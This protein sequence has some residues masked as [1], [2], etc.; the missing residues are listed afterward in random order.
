MKVEE[1]AKIGVQGRG[2]TKSKEEEEEED[3]RRS[4]LK[5]KQFHIIRFLLDE[6][7]RS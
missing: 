3:S 6:K 4:G 2:R 7:R 5:K 1:M